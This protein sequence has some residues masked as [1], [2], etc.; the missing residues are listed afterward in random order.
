MKCLVRC[1][2][3]KAIAQ[4]KVTYVIYVLPMPQQEPLAAPVESLVL[5]F[6][7]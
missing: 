4:L 5:E 3:C 7:M 1:L 2:A 6:Q